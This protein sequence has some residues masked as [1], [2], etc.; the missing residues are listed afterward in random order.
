MTR[1][2][3]RIYGWA[4]YDWA[5]SAYATT[6]MAGF[7]P[8]F[9]KA[10]YS[11]DTDATLSTAQLGVANA[12]SSIIVVLLAPLLG[13]IADAGGIRKRFLLLFAFLGILMSAALAL[14]G[15]GQWELAAFVYVLGN[16]GF[17]GSNIFYDAFLPSV[18]SED[19][20]DKVSGLGYALGYLGGGILFA[21]NVAMV[22]QPEWFGLADAAAG[23]KASFISVALWWMLFA[24]P[25][26][27]WVKEKRNTRKIGTVTL[28]VLGYRRLMRT[29]HKIKHL[30][31][32]FLFLVA[33]WFYIDG[34]DTIIRMAV[35]Y[36]MAIGFEAG[37]LIKALLLVQFIGFPATILVAKL[38]QMWDTKK[39]IYLTLGFYVLIAIMAAFMHDVSSF[40]LLAAMIALVQGGIQA[41]SR[42]YYSKMIPAEYAAEFFG[43]YN[44]LGKFATVLGP[45]LIGAVALATESSRAGIASVAV[46]FVIG[47]VLLYMVDEKAVAEEVRG[48]MR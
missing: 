40:Y 36:G 33:Y 26:V 43:F 39:A 27:L 11:A 37:D 2:S 14:V 35:D 41:M 31:G 46:F 42:S 16:I 30:R 21:L 15:K 9:F 44:F 18:T 38:A 45:L 23:V 29:F 34:V 47:A 24:L 7:F 1:E 19:R 28:T 5:N 22:Q 12:V 10:F 4:L 20:F 32:L 13:A 3:K 8:L 25:F 6:V 17:M 48:A